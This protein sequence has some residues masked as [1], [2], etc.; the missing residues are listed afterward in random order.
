MVSF[1]NFAINNVILIAGPPYQI[2]YPFE[3][4]MFSVHAKH[5]PYMFHFPHACYI[6]HI[7]HILRV[8]HAH[9]TH[10]TH[11]TRTVSFHPLIHQLILQ[12]DSADMD[13]V[14]NQVHPTRQR[15]DEPE[16]QQ[17]GTGTSGS[18]QNATCRLCRWNVPKDVE[19]VLLLERP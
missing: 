13:L 9:P 19:Y 3:R 10:H 1:R 4:R 18:Q 16:V 5:V 6:L 12:S 17:L 8:L 2:W 7:L 15:S 14:N 11:H